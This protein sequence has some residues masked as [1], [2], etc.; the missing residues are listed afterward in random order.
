M[1]E[2][3]K[4]DASASVVMS[5]NN[6][7]VCYLLEKF[8]SDN[9]KEKYLRPL[10]KGEKIGAFSLS[11]PQSGSDASNMNT[12]A[13]LNGD[14]YIVNGT[15]N[16]VTNGINSDYVILFAITTQEI[17]YKGISVFLVESK[18]LR[19]SFEFA[20]ESSDILNSILFK[21]S[22]NV[23]TCSSILSKYLDTIQSL[24]N[25]VGTPNTK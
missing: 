14:H 24:K 7:L 11:E 25:L 15:K 2:I 18:D 20:L 9:L 22:L 8:A 10:A 16:W 1:E 3:S 17:G 21:L 5:V 19:A 4:A 6:S 13:K 12:I 23:L